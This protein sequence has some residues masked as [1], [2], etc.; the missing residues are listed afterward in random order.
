MPRASLA[1]VVEAR[2]DCRASAVEI[3]LCVDVVRC[4]CNLCGPAPEELLLSAGGRWDRR[5]KHFAGEADSSRTM[6][7][8]AAQLPAARFFAR[9]LEAHRRGE[10]VPGPDGTPCYTWALVGGRRGGKS[11]LGVKA[12]IS[13]AVSVPRAVCWVS[14]SEEDE[15]PE[16]ERVI[17][18]QA[19]SSWYRKVGLGY[20]FVHGSEIELLS[21][22]DPDDLKRGR[23][24]VA[25]IN[26][27]QKQEHKVYVNLAGAAA[28]HGGLVIVAA[29]PPDDERGEWVADLV[30]RSRAGRSDELVF[31][32]D[33]RL[34]PHV[35]Q[36]ALAALAKRMDER[37]YRREVLGEFLART[38]VVFYAFSQT[39]SVR[40]VGTDENGRALTE[41]TP[42]FLARHFGAPAPRLHGIDF[43][44]DQHMA[45][46]TLRFFEDPEDPAG[47]PL[48]WFT[49]GFTLEQ[50]NEEDLV[51]ALE[52][53]G[54]S[55]E[56]I[57]VIDASGEWQDTDRTRGRASADVMRRRGWRRIY[58]PDAKMKRNPPIE[59]RLAVTNGLF[60]DATGKRKGFVDPRAVELVRAFRLWQT[61][62]GGAPSARSEYVHIC[63]AATYPPYRV[64]P[65]RAIASH[66]ITL[67]ERPRRR[68][69]EDIGR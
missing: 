46:A 53:R 4:R 60:R 38:D 69:L 26:E 68:G 22:Y 65:R 28:D 13:Y 57:C 37:T 67:I 63:D 48:T 58:L 19:P 8:Q 36:R 61:R 56:D 12:L 40:P 44:K 32:I 43:G 51:T 1:E 23:C 52:R 16:I 31:D 7:L 18:E 39:L 2:L 45:A 25:L 3:D 34:N 15:A 47:P 5:G 30:D 14:I 21:S 50:G 33:P 49:D 11:D 29:N 20:H 35:D 64:F 59:E 9:W 41:V 54:Y 62:Q 42:Y 66:S 55:G 24:D 27:A 10:S 6:A 17:R